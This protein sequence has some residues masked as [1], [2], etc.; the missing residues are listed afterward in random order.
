MV[1]VVLDASAKNLTLDCFQAEIIT[2]S[3]M[4]TC[5][6]VTQSKTINTSIDSIW[7][8]ALFLQYRTYII[9]VPDNVIT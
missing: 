8:N 4:R 2:G 3:R 5:V 1:A 9:K 7:H 6:K